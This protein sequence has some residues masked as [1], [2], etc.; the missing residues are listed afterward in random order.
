M[1]YLNDQHPKYQ[2]TIYTRHGNALPFLSGKF[3][4]LRLVKMQ[5]EYLAK[6]NDRYHRRYYIDEEFF[7][8]EYKKGEGTYYKILMRKVNDWEEYHESDYDKREVA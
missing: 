7:D 3:D 5:L 1:Y 2:Y 4:S 6:D 8:N